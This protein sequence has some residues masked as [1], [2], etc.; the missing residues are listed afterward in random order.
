MAYLAAED[1]LRARD[2]FEEALPELEVGGWMRQ[3]PCCGSG[4]LS[5]NER[6]VGFLEVFFGAFRIAPFKGLRLYKSARR[7]F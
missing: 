4:Q 2:A 5:D 3:G 7:R 1:F 6:C